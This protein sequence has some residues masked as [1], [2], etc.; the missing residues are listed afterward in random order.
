VFE[1]ELIVGEVKTVQF[2]LRAIFFHSLIHMHREKSDI[3]EVVQV[4]IHI[5]ENEIDK[6]LPVE[7]LAFGGLI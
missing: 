1:S 7:N 6:G 5:F 4:I 3:S 2:P